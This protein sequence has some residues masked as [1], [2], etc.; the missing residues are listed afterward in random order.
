MIRI[1]GYIALL[2][3]TVGCP[4]EERAEPH[5]E[6][7][8]ITKP[9]PASTGTITTTDDVHAIELSQGVALAVRCWESCED[10]YGACATPK[11]VVDDGTLLGIRPVYR[12]AGGDGELVLVAKRAGTTTLHVT[13]TCGSQSY[14]V[15]VD[16]RPR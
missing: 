9:P 2:V 13:S 3:S 11:L 1:L 14:L 5:I 16:S 8:G 6:L 12:L 15:R 7:Y 4:S 10:T